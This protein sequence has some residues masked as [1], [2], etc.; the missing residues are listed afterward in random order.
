M[1]THTHTNT[2]TQEVRHAI[3]NK[4]WEERSERVEVLEKGQTKETINWT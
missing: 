4:M 3:K 2:H 1:G